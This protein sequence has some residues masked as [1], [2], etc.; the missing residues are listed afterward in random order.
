MHLLC[1]LSQLLEEV[2]SVTQKKLYSKHSSK[3]V[4]F[5]VLEM[6]LKNSISFDIRCK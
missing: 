1:L 3:T 2:Q 4:L 6:P 5:E